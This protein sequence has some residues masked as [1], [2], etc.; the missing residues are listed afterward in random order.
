[1]D[2]SYWKTEGRR[3]MTGRFRGAKAVTDPSKLCV[4]CYSDGKKT[5]ATFTIDKGETYSIMRW[6][7]VC[8]EHFDNFVERTEK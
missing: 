4:D 8:D 3:E 6:V 7:D 5:P 1:V 2:T